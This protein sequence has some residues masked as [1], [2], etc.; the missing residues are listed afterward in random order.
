VS[1]RTLYMDCMR[2]FGMSPMAW[3]GVRL[4]AARSKLS[5]DTNCN[6]TRVATECG[7]GHLGRFASYYRERIGVLPSETAQQRR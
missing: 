4:D 7:F 1:P 6:V 3:L 2:Q 5:S